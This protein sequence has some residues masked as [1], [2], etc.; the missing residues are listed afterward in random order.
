MKGVIIE[1]C[2]VTE[3]HL[4]LKVVNK[5]MKT[6]VTVGDVVQAGFVIINSEVGLGHLTVEPMIFRFG[7]P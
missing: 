7:K 3:A 1:S 2:E 5:K 6:E 4:Y